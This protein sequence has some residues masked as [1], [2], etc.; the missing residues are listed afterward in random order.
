MSKD[1]AKYVKSCQK[2][3]LAKTT[4]HIKSLMTFTETPIIPF[5]TVYADT[6]RSFP[7][8][9]NGN[10]YAITLIC[11][12]TKDLVMVP[13]PDKLEKTVAKAI[14]ENF[15]LTYGQRR[16]LQTLVQNTKTQY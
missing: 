2:F 13:T 8:S 16:S 11:D 9:I 12:L 14:F 10:E 4:E 15:V 7:R 5:D 1:I 6:I 3:H